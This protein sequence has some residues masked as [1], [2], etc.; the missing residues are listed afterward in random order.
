MDVERTMEFI[1]EQQAKAEVLH[2]KN[3]ERH[4]KNEE[5]VPPS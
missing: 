1:L 3:E 2:V 5:M 4:A